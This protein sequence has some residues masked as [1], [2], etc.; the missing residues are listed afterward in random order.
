M[1]RERFAW[2]LALVLVVAGGAGAANAQQ[3]RQV[4][5]EFLATIV[6]DDPNPLPRGPS[7]AERGLPLPELDPW[8]EFTPPTGE[9]A[10]PPEYA[11]NEGLLISWGSFNALLTE[12]TVGITTGDPAAIVYIVVFGPSQQA[13][14]TA[15]LQGAG[16][17]L[18]QV[19][20]ITYTTDS[21]WIRDYGPRFISEDGQ[22]AI[23]DHTYNRPLRPLDD[24]FPDFLS[25]LW[26]EPQYDLPLV[27]GG[28]NF[29]LYGDG[30]AFMTEL[31]LDENW[32]VSE[33]E[34]IDLFAS[35]ESLQLEITPG[36]P[37]WY[38]STRHIDMWMLPVRDHEVIIGQYEPA[39][40]EPYTI[41]E[42]MTTELTARGYTVHRTPGWNA[43]GT[44]YTYT[45]AVVFNELVFVSEF[46]GYPAENA[47][48][49]VTYQAAF[50][51]H[52]VIPVDCS[53]II[54]SAGAIHCIVMHV[55]VVLGAGG[56]PFADGFE[57]GDLASWSIVIP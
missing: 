11:P 49:L 4:P 30:E 6:D 8:T 36:F 48:A 35:Y 21:V 39:D 10:T 37:T 31:I 2:S 17:N 24:A 23:V 34:V 13:S 29:H 15:T 50:P 18:D 5:R 14:A 16:A 28:G 33:Q 55:P 51:D 45:N 19:E 40:G 43:G 25:T 22:R 12:L 47:A 44:H 56:L 1:R 53:D 26:G 7:E 9:V 32:G 27:H 20:F 52:Q 3:A 41:T 38:D 42:A 54:H 57:S 46:A